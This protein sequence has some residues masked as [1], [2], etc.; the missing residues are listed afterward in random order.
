[1]SGRAIRRRPDTGRGGLNVDGLKILYI[2]EEADIFAKPFNPM[3]LVDNVK[4]IWSRRD[5]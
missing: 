3:K 2:E 1:M 5:R 4:K